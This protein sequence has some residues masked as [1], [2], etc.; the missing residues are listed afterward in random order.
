MKLVGP[1]NLTLVL[2]CV[3]LL[4]DET[5][6]DEKSDL[7]YCGELFLQQFID[8]IEHRTSIH[9]AQAHQ[10]PLAALVQDEAEIVD[11]IQYGLTV[12][13]AVRAVAADTAVAFLGMLVLLF[14]IGSA[15]LVWVIELVF[16]KCNELLVVCQDTFD[17][18]IL[19]VATFKYDILRHQLVDARKVKHSL[20]FV[21]LH[22]LC[23]R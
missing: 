15:I 1:G 19:N 4:L 22:F 20:Y 12:L 2:L 8:E 13:L 5:T 3:F 7:K 10:R 6:E 17:Q 21:E 16:D 14:E 23:G 18:G 9:D 11:H